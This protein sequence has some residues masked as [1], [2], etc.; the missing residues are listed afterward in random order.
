[1]NIASN[2]LA[3]VDKKSRFN[4]GGNFNTYVRDYTTVAKLISGVFGKFS[5]CI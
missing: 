1:L 5:Y 2:T 3:T 4:T